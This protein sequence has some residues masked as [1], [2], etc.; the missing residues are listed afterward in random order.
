[1][2]WLGTNGNGKL[3][4]LGSVIIIPN[5]HAALHV[6]CLIPNP[7]LIPT[8]HPTFHLSHFLSEMST[9]DIPI[10]LYLYG[11]PFDW[12]EDGLFLNQLIVAENYLRF[13]LKSFEQKRKSHVDLREAIW[14]SNIWRSIRRRYTSNYGYPEKWERNAPM[15]LGCST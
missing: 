6:A 4:S 13:A 10:R 8:T 12:S 1:M 5:L 11:K 7:R 3:D 15:V 14:I 2:R 9:P